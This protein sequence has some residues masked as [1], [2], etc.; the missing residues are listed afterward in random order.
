MTAQATVTRNKPQIL[1]VKLKIKSD[2]DYP[3]REILGSFDAK[4]LSKVAINHRRRQGTSREHEW[5]NP[6]A[7]DTRADAERD[8]LEMME[9]AH[10]RKWMMQIVGFATVDIPC[11]IT[12]VTAKV[13]PYHADGFDN[14]DENGCKNAQ[15]EIREEI[16]DELTKMGFSIREIT[17]AMNH[18]EIEE[19]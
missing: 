9:F 7:A 19:N 15:T 16:S 14:D 18:I 13:G 8:Y 10:E 3:L 1:T 11:G 5:F 2:P 17:H 6:A 4:P 12:S